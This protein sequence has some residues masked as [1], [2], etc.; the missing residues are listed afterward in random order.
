MQR[1]NLAKAQENFKKN[2]DPRELA[3]KIFR[4]YKAEMAAM[5][6]N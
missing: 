5:A 1:P 4:A 2:N 6:S 3:S